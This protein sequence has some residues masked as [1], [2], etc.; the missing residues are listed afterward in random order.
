MIWY[1]LAISS[2]SA[3]INTAASS[4]KHQVPTMH[5]PNG[6]GPLRYTVMVIFLFLL[7]NISLLC[8]VVMVELS[9][10]AP[11]QC[12][13]S[14][15]GFGGLAFYDQQNGPL[16]LHASPSLRGGAHLLDY[17]NKPPFLTSGERCLVSIRS[18][19]MI[20]TTVGREDV[21]NVSLASLLKFGS[22]GLGEAYWNSSELLNEWFPTSRSPAHMFTTINDRL[23]NY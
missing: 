5:N 6:S 16:P 20:P 12:S 9:M 10:S 18:Q 4:T 15:V 11:T 13:Q 7:A 8:S 1:L 21:N 14:V 23:L 2:G 17:I 3:P 22:G 19:L